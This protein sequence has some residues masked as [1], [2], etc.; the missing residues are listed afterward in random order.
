MTVYPIVVEIFY[1]QLQM[2]TAWWCKRK[3]QRKNH[4]DSLSGG[5][6]MSVENV[7]AIHPNVE[8]FQSGPQWCTNQP[9]DIVIRAKDKMNGAKKS[10]KNQNVTQFKLRKLTF[11]K[12]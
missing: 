2:S 5:S 4:W 1:S 10:C 6:C 8:I 12:L 11:K 7:M 3:S 9:A